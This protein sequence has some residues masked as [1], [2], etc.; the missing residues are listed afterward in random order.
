MHT[1][2]REPTAEQPEPSRKSIDFNRADFD[3]AL[4]TARGP[5]LKMLKLFLIGATFL[6]TLAASTLISGVIEER[7][8]RQAGVL[9][10]FKQS[11]GPEQSLSNPVL[12]VPYITAPDKP[13][14]YLKIAPAHLKVAAKMSPEE[15][16]RGMFHATVYGAE[17]TL[18][19]EFAI[20]TEAKLN[21]LIAITSKAFWS[22]AFIMLETSGLSGVTMNDSFTLNG[23]SLHWQNCWEA[24]N[25]GDDC[26][27][28]PAV[29][30]HPH[31][32]AA[33][34][35][36]TSLPFKGALNLRGTGTFKLSFQGKEME[37]A[38][39]GAWG[40]PSFMG[41][42]L[43]KSSTVTPENFEAQWQALAYSAPQMW[44]SGQLVEAASPGAVT[45][46]VSLLE[47]TPAYRMIHRASKYNVLFVI[48]A[49]TAYFLFE[50]L[51][52]SRIHVVQY[53]MLGASLTLFA[54]LLASFSEA[55]GYEKGYALA[56]GLVLAQAS[57]FTGTVAGRL[58]LAGM[59][60]GMLATLFGFLYVLLSLETYSMMVGSVGLFVVLSIVMV[61]TRKVDWSGGGRSGGAPEPE[62]AP[63]ADAPKTH[64]LASEV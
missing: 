39:S 62:T 40:T 63:E 11:W 56:A 4:E 37:A 45:A 50:I 23:Q 55:M 49:F 38:I 53:G 5:A 35:G 1:D 6:A 15:R 29:I 58:S 19:G 44:T 21:E 48:L 51:T 57:L 30:A 24:L 36:G 10:E 8:S 12:V 28:S 2:P 25:R 42:V 17:V 52:G 22:D 61:L 43:P 59:F 46:G 31:L 18:D 60:A 33:P 47:A 13:R 20:P 9:T 34:L 32:N 7:E 54:L 14:K 27:E 41:N 3:R 64:E 16:K 26:Q